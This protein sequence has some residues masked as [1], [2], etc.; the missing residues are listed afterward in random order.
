M[1]KILIIEDE[2]EIAEL[3]K[4]HDYLT[5]GGQEYMIVD[6]D[7]YIRTGDS[8]DLQAHHLVICAR[9]P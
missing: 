8:H 7:Y 3:E 2:N 6:F 9:K 4:D 5:A 1:E